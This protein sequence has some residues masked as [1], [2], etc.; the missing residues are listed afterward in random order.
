MAIGRR[1]GRMT[2]WRWVVTLGAAGVLG[3]ATLGLAAPASASSAAPTGAARPQTAPTMYY[4][5]LGDSLAAGAGAS[6][7]SNDYVN[8]VYQHEL[9]R[10]PG[11][12]VENLSCGGATTGTMLNGGGACTYTSGTQLGDA[13]AFLRAHPGQIAFLT[14]D[15]GAN[16][17]DG[18]VP[19]GTSVDLA[20]LQQGIAAM[21]SQLPQILAALAQ[22][23]PGLPIFGMNYYDPF[24]AAWLTGGSG[25]SLAQLSVTLADTFNDDLGQIYGA[26]G[27]PTADVADAFATDDLAMTGSYNGQTL[28]QDVADICNWTLMCSS[29]DIHA[30]NTGHGLIA[31][32][33]DQQIDGWFA[34]GGPGLTLASSGGG[35]Y[36]LGHALFY[37]ALNSQPLA[38]PIVGVA[39]I[40]DHT[41]YW[42]AGADGGVFAFGDAGFY[43]SMGG[44]ALNAPVVGIA[45]TP[46]GKGYWEV[47]ADGGVFAFGD[48]G[49]YGSMGG[50]ALNAPVVAL[51]PSTDGGGYSMAARDGGVFA[52]GD[53]DY[54]G[55]MATQ[56]L[57]TPVVAASGT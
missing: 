57:R 43:G 44:K 2:A 16:N 37:G 30:N 50:K 32:A 7:A 26:D 11:L 10:F 5:A 21:Q 13:E 33:F 19:G 17:V 27:Y 47:A 18:C 46:D 36:A 31:A 6:S 49:F 1:P 53:A 34:G 56:T 15:I 42:L 41:G 25:Q 23:D 39:E 14:I 8:L 22:A 24:L 48:A 52:F 29:A 20:C 35:V 45:A 28:P 54:P 40:P 38:A 51:S 55:S 9:S 4:V 12:Q 3:V